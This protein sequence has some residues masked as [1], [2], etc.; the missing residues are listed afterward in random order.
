MGWVLHQKNES[1]LEAFL[2]KKKPEF[3]C[4]VCSVLGDSIVHM[5]Y[6]LHM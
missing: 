1:Q 3:E 2:E 5:I 4:G 6:I